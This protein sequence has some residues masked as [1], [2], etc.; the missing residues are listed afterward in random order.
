MCC[1]ATGAFYVVLI[2]ESIFFTGT[3]VSV[4]QATYSFLIN[5]YHSSENVDVATAPYAYYNST[6]YGNY[7]LWKTEPGPKTYLGLAAG[8]CATH[9]L[10][11]V[12][13]AVG[14]YNR[15]PGPLIAYLVW[16]LLI[17][18]GLVTASFIGALVILN[19]NPVT[20]KYMS[21][22]TIAV[23]VA[24]GI[25]FILSIIFF[26]IILRCVMLFRK[27]RSY[28]TLG[29]NQNMAVRPGS[30]AKPSAPKY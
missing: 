29:E 5:H 2:L 8:V 21:H 6:T 13:L 25:Q 20:M 12:L 15:R 10:A 30:Y 26:I 7:F 28:T 19:R 11:I 1:R 27:E 24:G 23:G 16:C 22:P 14:H 4:I 18:L 3:V 9:L 17:R